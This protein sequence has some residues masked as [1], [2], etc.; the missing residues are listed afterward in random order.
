MNVHTT[1][2]IARLVAV[3]ALVC[4]AAATKRALKLKT[5]DLTESL[6]R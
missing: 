1:L 5:V 3:I 4:V 2:E 6:R